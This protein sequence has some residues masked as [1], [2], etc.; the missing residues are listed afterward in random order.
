MNEK[1]FFV[2][3][4]FLHFFHE[5]FPWWSNDNPPNQLITPPQKVTCHQKKGPWE[6]DRIRLPVP[7][8]LKGFFAIT[9]RKFNIAPKPK[10]LEH[11]LLSYWE[12]NFSG[13][14][15]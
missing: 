15:C 11:F 3:L 14:N 10:W 8:F 6:K 1:T 9:P 7:T 12:G 2:F 13:A 4:A 5:Q